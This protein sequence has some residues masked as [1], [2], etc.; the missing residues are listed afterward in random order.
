MADKNGRIRI[1]QETE[2]LSA[3]HPLLKEAILKSRESQFIEWQTDPLC[4]GEKRYDSPAEL[5]LSAKRSYQAAQPYAQAGKKTC[6]LNFASSVTPGGGVVKGASAQEESLCRIS[7]LYF[8]ISDRETAGM[9]Y[10]K[11][12]QD[13]RS[14]V[15]GRENAD[16]CI[17]TP[18]VAVVRE[19]TFDC[20]FLPEDKWYWVDV[21]TCAAP[22]LRI[23]AGEKSFTPT[24]EEF[25]RTMESRLRRIFSVAAK[26]RTEVLI[27]G[28]FGCGVFRNPPELV[29]EAFSKVYGEFSH[30]FETI[31]F[32]V[33]TPGAD[34]TNYRAF[35]NVPGIREA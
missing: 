32:A 30:C 10:D 19:D 23:F 17:Y 11:H 3:E 7:T 31:E 12:W 25:L 13:I 15:M 28:A 24:D 21:I 20:A 33:Y 1:F 18:G 8:S 35:L 2:R 9:F 27:L 14:G 34:D 22:D 26:N 5:V 16:D 4:P 29:A 6:V